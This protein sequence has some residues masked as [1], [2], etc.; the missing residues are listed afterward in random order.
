MKKI[1]LIED[2]KLF[3]R[4]YKN[5]LKKEGFTV[6]FLENGEE[7]VAETKKFKP[8]LIM[9][10]L[11][12]PKKDGFETLADLKNDPE[13]KDVPVIVLSTL[14]SEADVSK[15]K[16]LGA[17]KYIFKSSNSLNIVLKEIKK[18]LNK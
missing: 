11:V 8:D 13:T 12:M 9:L 1:L 16:S 10:D 2:D 15:I 5:S 4:I 17:N 6:S 7:A 14:E 3:V 18:F